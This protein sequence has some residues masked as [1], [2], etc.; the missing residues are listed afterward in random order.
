MSFFKFLLNISFSYCS[1]HPFKVHLVCCRWLFISATS[2]FVLHFC[3]LVK[4][5]KNILRGSVAQNLSNTFYCMCEHSFFF[6]N[7]LFRNMA[8]LFVICLV[9]QL[10]TTR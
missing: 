1:R 6:L 4:H 7:I 9:H 5:F 3:S 8:D 2:S 10:V